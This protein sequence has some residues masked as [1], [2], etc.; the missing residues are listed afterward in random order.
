VILSDAYAD[1][2][3]SSVL[4]AEQIIERQMWASVGPVHRGSKRA[5]LPDARISTVPG[6][7][8]GGF[9]AA[10]RN[11]SIQEQAFVTTAPECCF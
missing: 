3:A 2:H 8:A 6:D 5:A 1:A 4:A 11:S 7:G 10:R 9:R